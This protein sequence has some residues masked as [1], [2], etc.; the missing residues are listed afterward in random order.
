MTR[1]RKQYPYQRRNL[2][3]PTGNQMMKGMVDVSKMAIGGAV[4]IGGMNVVANA[5]KKW[6]DDGPLEES[7][8]SKT[9]VGTVPGTETHAAVWETDWSGTWGETVKE[10]EGAQSPGESRELG[11]AESQKDGGECTA[12]FS[13]GF[14]VNEHSAAG[15]P[16]QFR[17]TGVYDGTASVPGTGSTETETE[18]IEKEDTSTKEKAE[19]RWR[20]ELATVR[21]HSKFH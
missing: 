14:R 8:G 3:P 19:F 11:G 6:G 7:A 4:M 16:F 18:K 13:A 12:E 9:D 2:R 10:R 17:S 21:C 5:I 20:A 15:R 1:K